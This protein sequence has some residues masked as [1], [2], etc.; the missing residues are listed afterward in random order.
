MTGKQRFF[1][2]LRF[3]Q[4]DRPPHF[5]IAFQLTREAFGMDYPSGKALAAAAGAA[6]DRLLTAC[7]EIYDKTV[8]AFAWDAFVVLNPPQDAD[9]IRAARRVF[10]DEIAVGGIV[11]EGV[12]SIDIIRDWERFAADLLERDDEVRRWA[13]ALCA[14]AVAK[15]DR[16]ADAGADFIVL[17]SDVAFNGGPFISP[18]HFRRHVQPYLRRLVDRVRG[19]GKVAVFHSDGQLMPILD[20]LLDCRPHVLQSIDPMAGM[21]IA[22]VKRLTFGRMALMGNVQ[23]S[24]LQ[25]GPPEAIRRSV[26][27]CLEHASAGGGYVF[28]SSNTIFPGVPLDNY[29]LMLDVFREFCGGIRPAG[30]GDAGG[31]RGN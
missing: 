15:V 3:E 6:R 12:I 1:Q 24:V 4:P 31:D 16:L 29:R 23:C 18:A 9:G 7:A 21:D 5:E 8:S 27:Y 22:E 26:L 2:A 10:G 13:E 30:R 20:Q 17:A 25:E 14:A 11:W 19:H 28:S